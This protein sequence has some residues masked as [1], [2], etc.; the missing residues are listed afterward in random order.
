MR[1][2]QLK[3]GGDYQ[4]RGDE[5][6]AQKEPAGR[7]YITCI[8]GTAAERVSSLRWQV[9]GRGGEVSKQLFSISIIDK[10]WGASRKRKATCVVLSQAGV[11]RAGRRTFQNYS[12][13]WPV[14]T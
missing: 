11:R 6:G 14:P 12:F 2:Q 5:E 4:S 13:S 9:G 3:A 7:E 8:K 10:K 1:P